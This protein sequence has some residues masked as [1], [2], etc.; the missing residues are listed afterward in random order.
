M[1]H[2]FFWIM[3][4]LA[5]LGAAFGGL[6]AVSVGPPLTPRLVT[7]NVVALDAHGEPIHNLNS[8]DL[9][10]FDRGKPQRIAFFRPADPPL[11][12]SP[13]GA[14]E[15]SNHS[16]ARAPHTVVIVLD[17][18]N[19]RVQTGTYLN[20]QLARA[21]EHLTSNEALYLYILTNRGELE[22]IHELPGAPQTQPAD[23]SWTRGITGVLD[24]ALGK[25]SGFRTASAFDNMIAS[26]YTQ[27]GLLGQ[28]LAAFPGR[29]TILWITHGPPVFDDSGMQALSAVMTEGDT[30][31]YPVDLSY[32]PG[33]DVGGYEDTGL[34]R[35]SGLTDG[36]A[37]FS[38]SIETALAHAVADAQGAYEV[39]Y[40]PTQPWDGK[41]HKVRVTSVRKDVRIWAETGYY[42][43]VAAPRT[44]NAALAATGDDS[45]IGLR[46]TVSPGTKGPG[47]IHL[48]IRINGAD[49]P[50][51]RTANQWQGRLAYTVVEYESDPLQASSGF[52]ARPA[53]F[54]GPM[55][56]DLNLRR[57]QRDLVLDQ[58]LDFAQDLKLDRN[59]RSIRLV[60][61]DLSSN[62]DGTLTIPIVLE[63]TPLH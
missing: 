42:A 1:K 30:A 33:P 59:I 41:Y 38:A 17:L 19:E 54:A 8:A 7:L 35:V 45:R 61:T 50:F 11:L 40:Y 27:L 23:N 2:G 36:R 56:I 31:I 37:Y 62:R 3:P 10:V 48:Q 43:E 60:V 58:G 47:S 15:Y 22:A 18:L 51:Y 39:G 34:E 46:A 49:L 53:Q 21:L 5:F 14:N 25:L 24:G 16:A 32:G 20:N 12:R 63:R 4:A 29:K 26:T 9:R 57:S 55:A 28:R 52:A 13:L 44:R 6:A